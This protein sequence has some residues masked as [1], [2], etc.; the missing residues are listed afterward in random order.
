MASIPITW[1]IDGEKVETV[2]D[3][4]FFGSKITA[5]GNCSHEIKRCLLLGRK[6]CHKPREHIKN[7]RHY[8]ADESPYSQRYS[9]SNSHVWMWELDHKKAE[10]QRIDAFELWCWRRLLSVPWTAWRSNQSVLKE[11]SPCMFIGRTDAEAAILWLPDARSQLIRKRPWCWER[12][13][14]NEEGGERRWDDWMASPTQWTWVWANSGRQWSTGK[15]GLLQFTGLQRVRHDLANK[16]QQE[17][18]GSIKP[19]LNITGLS[20]ERNR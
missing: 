11:I 8:F 12:L 19:R 14:A 1:Q 9:F 2:T 16:Q 20:C 10:C 13:R 3:F 5:E 18:I 4:V 7:Q 15:P 6:A 17:S